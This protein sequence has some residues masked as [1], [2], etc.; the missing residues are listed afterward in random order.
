MTVSHANMSIFLITLAFPYLLLYSY[1]LV[2]SVGFHHRDYS[3]FSLF[4]DSHSPVICLVIRW[5]HL[6]AISSLLSFLHLSCACW[7]NAA[8]T[9]FY[10]FSARALVADSLFGLFYCCLHSQEYCKDQIKY[11]IE[12]RVVEVNWVSDTLDERKDYLS[13][14]NGWLRCM[15][16]FIS[17]HLFMSVPFVYFVSI[18]SIC[19]L[20]VYFSYHCSPEWLLLFTAGYFTVR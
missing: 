15:I 10:P 17:V 8:C 3:R 6:Y 19:A 18:H 1:I 13:N 20:R 16:C 11:M 12:I 9:G 7:Y 2:V 4:E 14:V 5:W